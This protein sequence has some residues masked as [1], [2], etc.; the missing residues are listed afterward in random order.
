MAIA[1]FVK[2]PNSVLDYTLSWADWLP[3][4][5][6]IN[7]ATATGETGITIGSVSRTATTSTAWISGGTAGKSYNVTIKIV[8]T[9]GRTDE[10][11]I[12]I[13]CKDL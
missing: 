13:V 2:D 11:T 10:R 5:D 1:R 12:T 8:T 7:T 9:L 6:T 4:G 3:P